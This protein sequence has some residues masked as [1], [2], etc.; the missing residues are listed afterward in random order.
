MPAKHPLLICIAESN[1]SDMS[2]SSLLKQLIEECDRAHLDVRVFSEFGS[3]TY[4]VNGMSSYDEEAAIDGT[5]VVSIERQLRELTNAPSKEVHIATT[6]FLDSRLIPM[7]S[8]KE[9]WRTLVPQTW[10]N[11]PPEINFRQ[12]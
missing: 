12:K 11:L 2:Y 7:G 5:A 8:V 3:Q 9:R 4:K 1:H 6:D 10:E